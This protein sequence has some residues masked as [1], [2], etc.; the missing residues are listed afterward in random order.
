MFSEVKNKVLNLAG[1]LVSNA[2]P[3]AGQVLR[4]NGTSSQWEPE[5]PSVSSSEI[6]DFNAATAAIADARITVQKAQPSGLASL[7][8]WRARFPAR[9]WPSS[10]AV[11]KRR[12]PC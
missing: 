12:R 5:D 6:T 8:A 10:A 4:W 11:P 9:P 1:R 2:A 3:A 7:A